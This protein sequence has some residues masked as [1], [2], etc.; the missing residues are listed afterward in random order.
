MFLLI[1]PDNKLGI[2]VTNGRC[3]NSF[4]L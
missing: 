1:K 2:R 4:V 3:C